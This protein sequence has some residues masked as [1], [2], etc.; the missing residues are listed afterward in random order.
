MGLTLKQFTVDAFNRDVN[1]SA[2]APDRYERWRAYRE[3]VTAFL[4]GALAE[5]SHAKTVLVAGAGNLNDIDVPALCGGWNAVTLSDADRTGMESGLS[6]QGLAYA[7]RE[8]ITLLEADYTGAEK[9][10]LFLTW[11]GM[12]NRGASAA[13]MAAYIRAALAALAADDAPVFG[14]QYDTVISCPVYTQLLYT[15]IEVFLKILLEAGLYSYEELNDILNAAYGA[16]PLI[17]GH[18]NDAL[19]AACKPDGRLVIL[20]DVV[21]AVTSSAEAGT[22]LQLAV[23]G[24]SDSSA[25]ESLIKIHGLELSLE[26]LADWERKTQCMQSRYFRWPF[27]DSKEYLVCGHLSRKPIRSVKP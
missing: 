8:K 24:F 3:Q 4:I 16:M 25:L 2:N 26:G 12:A 21:E 14:E 20:A 13:E 27:D 1:Q 17:L 6:R 23:N 9:S 5:A 10:G 18:Y 7:Q 19:L 15:Q 11:E 22:L